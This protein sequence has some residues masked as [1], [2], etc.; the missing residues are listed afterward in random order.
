MW[1]GITNN[2]L[3]VENLN[4]GLYSVRIVDSG[5]GEQTVEKFVIKNR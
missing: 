3:Q 4:P 5:S 1:K 2:N